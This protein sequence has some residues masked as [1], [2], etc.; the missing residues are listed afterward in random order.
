MYNREGKKGRDHDSLKPGFQAVFPVIDPTLLPS[1]DG[2]L[3]H[4]HYHVN[5]PGEAVGKPGVL[6]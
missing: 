2:Y 6:L 4:K 3:D 1:T 5:P